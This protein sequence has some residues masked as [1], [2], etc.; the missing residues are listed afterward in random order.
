MCSAK[1]WKPLECP[2]CGN[3]V[4]PRGRSVALEANPPQ[5]CMDG[6]YDRANYRHLW[7]EHDSTRHFSDPVGWAEHCE[8]CDRDPKCL[9]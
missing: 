1:C 9:P 8:A 3:D 2:T 7:D 5:C 4:P 6:Q